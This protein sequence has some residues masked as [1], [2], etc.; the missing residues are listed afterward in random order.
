[1]ASEVAEE[2]TK[3]STETP[4]ST[5]MIDN[6]YEFSAP[7]FYDFVNGE[8]DKD[9]RRAELW[10]DTS[11]AHAPSRTFSLFHSELLPVLGF[12]RS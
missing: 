5:T 12:P 9:R 2:G 8:S 7:R 3:S 4:T 1:M 10:F 6:V 11:L